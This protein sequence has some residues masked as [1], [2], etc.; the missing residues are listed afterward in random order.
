MPIMDAN[1]KLMRAIS[2]S[3]HAS[4]PGGPTRIT[5]A[6]NKSTIPVTV[7]QTGC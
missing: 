6:R 2:P 1:A 7:P 4:A 5:P 3:A